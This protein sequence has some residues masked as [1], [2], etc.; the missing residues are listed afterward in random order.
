MLRCHGL[1]LK[2]IAIAVV[3]AL[4]LEFQHQ[5]QRSDGNDCVFVAS[6]LTSI[7]NKASIFIILIS[8]TGRKIEKAANQKNLEH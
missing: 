6:K 2:L 8:H 7:V 5:R 1:E 4:Q 3:P